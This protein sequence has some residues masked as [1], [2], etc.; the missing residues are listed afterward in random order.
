[1]AYE[2]TLRLDE[3]ICF[4][5]YAATNAVTRAYRPLLAE[6]QLTYP[7]YLVMMV[8]WQDR[9][10]TSRSI[11]ER[12]Q[13]SANAV[14]PLLDRLE[15]AGFIRRLRDRR[16][17]RVV[18]IALT[19]QGSALEAA[20]SKAQHA[21]LCRTGLD[22]DAHHRLRDDLAALAVHMTAEPEVID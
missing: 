18:H 15:D 13:L 4:A 7:Q 14:S 21:V 5:L 3:Q 22:P 20:A 19:E 8:L 9:R 6:I 1:M 11:A 10:S 17:R 12:L 2:K 16:D